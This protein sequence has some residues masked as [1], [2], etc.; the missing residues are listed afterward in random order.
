MTRDED[1]LPTMQNTANTLLLAWQLRDFE[2]LYQMTLADDR[3]AYSEFVNRLKDCALL[4][5]YTASA[6]HSSGSRATVTLA[7]NYRVEDDECRCPAEPLRLWYENGIWKIAY[8]ELQ[9]LM[10][11]E[12]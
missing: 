7:L 2:L 9:R 3:P 11:R 10:L 1:V 5:G 6:G 4:T 12:N 8:N